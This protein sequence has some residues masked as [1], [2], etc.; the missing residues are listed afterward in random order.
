MSTVRSGTPGATRICPHCRTT[1]LESVSICP[2]CRH[3]VR[4][5]A[6]GTTDRE[7]ITALSVEGIV[8][9]PPGKDIWE[10]SMVLTIRNQRGE[11]VARQVVGVGALQPA[12]ERTFSLS[13]E[14]FRP[15]EG[16]SRLIGG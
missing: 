1:I 6:S 7:G 14:V 4:S 3:H 9:N 5:G 8:H 2:G 10:Y 13:V 15:A 11:E 16:V 12:E